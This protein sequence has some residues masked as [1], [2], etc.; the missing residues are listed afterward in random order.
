MD[1]NERISGLAIKIETIDTFLKFAE[2][3]G[4]FLSSTD[5]GHLQMVLSRMKKKMN[6]RAESEIRN[7]VWGVY[8]H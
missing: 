1:I 4:E 8:E 5:H 2:Q 6:K 3:N 7:V